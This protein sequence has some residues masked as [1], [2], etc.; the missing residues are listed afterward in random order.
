LSQI[1]CCAFHSLPREG[2]L[3]ILIISSSD[4]FYL[5]M[6]LACY[7]H[8]RYKSSKS[9]TYKEDGIECILKL[10]FAGM[11]ISIVFHSAWIEHLLLCFAGTSFAIQYGTGSMEGFLSQ[12]DVTLGDLTVKGQVRMNAF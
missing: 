2:I 1:R 4:E 11:H 3:L 5:V 7:F 10:N 6:Q 8:R 9:S 12:D